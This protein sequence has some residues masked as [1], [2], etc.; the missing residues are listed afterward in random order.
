MRRKRLLIGVI[1][2]CWGTLI[3]CTD[4][5]LNPPTISNFRLLQGEDLNIEVKEG[6]AVEV[7]DELRIDA[8]F[9][10]EVLLLQFV[11]SLTP[12]NE[13]EIEGRASQSWYTLQDTFFITGDISVASRKWSLPDN[14]L[15]GNYTFG[16]EAIDEDGNA[17]Q[18]SPI[19][20]TIQ[21]QAPVLVQKSPELEL[22]ILEG[23]D[24]VNFSVEVSSTRK[25]SAVSM[26]VTG[27][28][29]FTW[30]QASPNGFSYSL[31]SV[32]LTA[33]SDTGR[34]EINLTALDSTGLSSNV[35]T[36]MVILP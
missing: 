8:V 14:L 16:L 3:S 31:D 22:L 19:P 13:Q 21:N 32:Y 12:E 9:A 26:T 36:E 25:I 28:S 10:D 20:L 15:T 1:C 5:D 24:P 29:S 23:G 34:Y 30:L 18:V 2:L 27:D 6:D 17:A 33:L 4:E 11:A 7:P 35:L